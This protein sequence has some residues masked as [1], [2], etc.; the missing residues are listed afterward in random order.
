MA[1]QTRDIILALV[2]PLLAGVCVAAEVAAQPAAEGMPAGWTQSAR[3]VKAAAPDGD[4]DVTVT[5]I[6]CPLRLEAPNAPALEFVR[7][8]AGEVKIGQPGA[9]RTL[10][11]DKPLLI[12]ACEVTQEQYKAVMG[13]NPSHYRGLS[14]PVEKVSWKDGQEF[15]AKLSARTK[16]VTYRLP[17]D[18]EWE[19]ACRAGSNTRF[20]WGATVRDDVCWWGGN[21]GGRTHPVAEKLPNAF[22]LYDMAGNATEWASCAPKADAESS[23]REG[24]VL[25]G[26]PVQEQDWSLESGTRVPYPDGSKGYNGCGLRIVAEVPVQEIK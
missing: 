5:Y 8:A 21:R 15:C 13:V 22:G 6:R 12:S 17:T 19:Y 7:V 25:R 10:K 24:Y 3:T 16:G 14:N 11:L 2:V 23:E 18:A 20:Y 26:G 4:R 1:R 9:E